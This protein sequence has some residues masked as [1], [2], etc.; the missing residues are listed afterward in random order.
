[1]TIYVGMTQDLAAARRLLAD[2][3]AGM[4][5][6]VE[7]GPMTGEEAAGYILF[8][9]ER[10]PGAVEVLLPSFPVQR[11]NAHKWYVFSFEQ[12]GTVH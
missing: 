8:M 9:K 5:P 3:Q 2:R 12:L 4:C 7:M 6:D 11:E 10:F 1:M